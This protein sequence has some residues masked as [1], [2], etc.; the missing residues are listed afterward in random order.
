MNIAVFTGAT[1]IREEAHHSNNTPMQVHS[2]DQ[3]YSGHDPNQ[4]LQRL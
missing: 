1:V 3:Q 4:R 2:V